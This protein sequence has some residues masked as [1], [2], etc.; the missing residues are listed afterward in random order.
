MD[1]SSKQLW[2][3]SKHRA[4]G[5][6]IFSQA[7]STSPEILLSEPMP[8][9][10][11]HTNNAAELGGGGGGVQVLRQVP[12]RKLAILSDSEYLVRGAQG[13]VQQWQGTAWVGGGDL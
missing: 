6:G 4:G 2:K 9:N 11:R 3:G 13:K 5:F 12:G 1:G 10:I 8:L 7:D